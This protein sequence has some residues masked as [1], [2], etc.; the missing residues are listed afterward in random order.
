MERRDR[1]GARPWSFSYDTVRLS[2]PSGSLDTNNAG[3]VF[4]GFGPH[5]RGLT[6]EEI[7][8]EF[9]LDSRDVVEIPRLKAFSCHFEQS[10]DLE[11]WE[12]QGVSRETFE[13]SK[14]SRAFAARIGFQLINTCAP[15]L[16][17]NVPVMGE[18]CAWME[19]S[20]VVYCNSVLGARTNTEGRESST[21]CHAHR[22]D[23]LLGIPS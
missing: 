13:A 10:V 3:G 19:S 21:D 6:E 4:G 5:T 17:G 7:F 18:H 16:A 23:T 1:P 12:L 14:R 20:A 8:F 22:K 9:S 2:A 11:H 15:Y